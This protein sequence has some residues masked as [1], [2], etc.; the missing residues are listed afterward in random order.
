MPFFC[1]R[2]A[3]VCLIC[4]ILIVQKMV[5]A[6]WIILTCNVLML[7]IEKNVLV[8][9]VLLFLSLIYMLI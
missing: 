8:R 2:L 5:I 9:R 4:V 6:S 3:R 7:A 1:R